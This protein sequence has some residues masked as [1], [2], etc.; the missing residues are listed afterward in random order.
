MRPHATSRGTRRVTSHVEKQD[1][2][3]DFCEELQR[4][5]EEESAY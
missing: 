1:E 5:R 4:M 3:T 2:N